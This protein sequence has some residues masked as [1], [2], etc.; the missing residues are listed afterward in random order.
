MYDMNDFGSYNFPLS[1]MGKG[2]CYI[3]HLLYLLINKPVA[4]DWI[5]ICKPFVKS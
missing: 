5:R 4:T 2:Q 1:E 3:F